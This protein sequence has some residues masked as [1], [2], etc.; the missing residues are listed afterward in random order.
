MTSAARKPDGDTPNDRPRQPEPGAPSGAGWSR[1]P[2][3]PSPP[4]ES[5]APLSQADGHP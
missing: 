4:R 2:Q 5:H 1:R 3:E